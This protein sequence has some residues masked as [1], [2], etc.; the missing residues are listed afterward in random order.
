MS[1]VQTL[2]VQLQEALGLQI[3]C[4]SLTLNLNESKLSSYEAKT[5]QRIGARGPNRNPH[6]RRFDKPLDNRHT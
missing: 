4:G 2:V 3:V 1:D 6:P 5:H